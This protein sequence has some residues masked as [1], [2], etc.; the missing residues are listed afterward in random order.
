ML[1]I[2]VFF[3]GYFMEILTCCLWNFEFW[4][5]WMEIQDLKVEAL[6]GTI[7]LNTVL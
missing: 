6:V 5:F 7:E 3:D 4:L 1:C 2:M